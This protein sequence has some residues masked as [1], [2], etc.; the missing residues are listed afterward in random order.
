MT[1]LIRCQCLPVQRQAMILIWSLSEPSPG[2]RQTS[3]HPRPAFCSSLERFHQSDPS[4]GSDSRGPDHDY[5][6]WSKKARSYAS[7]LSS[8][9]RWLTKNKAVIR[10][11]QHIGSSKQMVFECIS[12]S[13][14]KVRWCFF[15]T[16]FRNRGIPGV[17]SFQCR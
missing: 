8:A 1:C 9:T 5:G 11:D 4:R 7:S 17:T 3:T 10:G 16:D 14:G 6:N 13:M 12:L 2:R 15:A